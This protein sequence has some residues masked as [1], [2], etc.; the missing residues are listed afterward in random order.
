MNSKFSDIWL[1]HVTG[2]KTCKNKAKIKPDP[3]SRIKEKSVIIW[4]W[5]RQGFNFVQIA[6]S[7]SY[8]KTLDK[9]SFLSNHISLKPRQCR[10]WKWV[11]NSQ[12]ADRP[13]GHVHV[14]RVVWLCEHCMITYVLTS[15]QSRARLILVFPGVLP[16]SFCSEIFAKLKSKKALS[17]K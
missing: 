14:K 7:W 15:E 2:T 16:P 10:L 4:S 6:C 3:P 8:A 9:T 11:K 13:W 12:P 1:F 17:S 5:T